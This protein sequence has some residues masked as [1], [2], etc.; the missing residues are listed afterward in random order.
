MYGDHHQQPQ[1][2]CRYDK[3]EPFPMS[4]EEPPVHGQP[5]SGY[6]AP[7]NPTPYHIL[8]LMTNLE[9]IRTANARIGIKPLRHHHNPELMELVINLGTAKALGLE[10]PP[11]LLARRRGDR[12]RRR[13]FITLLGGAIRAPWC[14]ARLPLYICRRIGR[15]KGGS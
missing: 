4:V 3:L 10:V 12:M 15:P 2:D 7:P 1:K 8:R 5:P 11:S 9:L 13:E 14:G 6:H